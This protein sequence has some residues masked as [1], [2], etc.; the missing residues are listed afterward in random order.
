LGP[1]FGSSPEAPFVTAK[2]KWRGGA[3]SGIG[4]AP[5]PLGKTLGN[6]INFR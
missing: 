5:S 3:V 2:P 6:L 4:S 1:M